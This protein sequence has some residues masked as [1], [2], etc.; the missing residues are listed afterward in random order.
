MTNYQLPITIH[1]NSGTVGIVERKHRIAAQSPN[2]MMKQLL[3]I[4]T[5]ISPLLLISPIITQASPNL[6][7]IAQNQTDNCEFN[8]FAN[9][10]PFPDVPK[11]HWAYDAV[12]K[13]SLCQKNNQTSTPISSPS[14][15]SPSISSPSMTQLRAAPTQIIIAG[16]SY[17]IEAFIWRDFMP[18]SPPDGKPMIASI[19]LIAEDG[20]SVPSNLVPEKLWALKSDDEE[21]WETNFTDEPR[22]S[23]G[24][25]E[26][27][28]RNGPK[29]EPDTEIDVVVQLSDGENKTYL[30][31]SPSQK[32]QRTS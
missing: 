8:D 10:N 1:R 11:N 20:N 28:A 4:T 30:L 15:S 7:L 26:I 14:I 6:E 19:K 32:I 23:E 24:M 16:R 29:W 17:K 9:G 21:V 5:L 3:F 12:T 31:R 2:I 27:V 22:F 13:L 18:I 25:V